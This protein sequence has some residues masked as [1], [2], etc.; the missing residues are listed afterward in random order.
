MLDFYE[1]KEIVDIWTNSEDWDTKEYHENQYFHDMI[2]QFEAKGSLEVDSDFIL[3]KIKELT[4]REQDI[5]KRRFGLFDYKVETL[6]EISERYNI[7]RER[8]RQIEARAIKQ[9]K[10]MCEGEI[11][12]PDY[13]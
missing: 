5:L 1:V 2:E 13:A 3:D 10:K 8:I 9:L 12:H 6:Q 4:S 11:Y 7:S